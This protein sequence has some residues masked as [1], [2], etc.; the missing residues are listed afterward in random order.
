MMSNVNE[1]VCVFTEAASISDR[2]C[3][4]VYTCTH[5]AVPLD[6]PGVDTEQAAMLMRVWEQRAG[7]NPT[8]TQAQTVDSLH[9][10][11]HL[12]ADPSTSSTHTYTHTHIY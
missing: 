2:P 12:A 5:T 10:A 7:G 9:T 6:L 11:A 8:Y 3:T 1:Y 4:P